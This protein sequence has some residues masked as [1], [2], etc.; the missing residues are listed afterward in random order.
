MKTDSELRVAGMKVLLSALGA[1]EAERFVALVNRERL[2]YTE[3]R[4]Q[5]W[6]DETVGTLADK[7]RTLR[8]REKN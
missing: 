4:R 5:Q 8:T 6:L 1:V 2:D 7:A 3:W